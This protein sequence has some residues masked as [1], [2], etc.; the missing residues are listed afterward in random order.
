MGRALAAG[1]VR[2][3]PYRNGQHDYCQWCE[4]RAACQFDE[5]AGDRARVLRTVSEQEFWTNVEGGQPHGDTVD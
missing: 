2:A 3:D 5:W 1:D 4:F